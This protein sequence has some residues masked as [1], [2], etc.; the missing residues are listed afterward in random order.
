MEKATVYKAMHERSQELISPR[1]KRRFG[2]DILCLMGAL[3][4]LAS[5]LLYTR[6]HPGQDVVA[7]ALY[8]IGVII[9]GAP[10]LVTA[11]RG[12]IKQDAAAAMEI[13]VSI[14]IIVSAL[15]SQYILAI[16]I[17]VILTFVH[18]LEEKSILGGRDAIENLI[19]MQGTTALLIQDGKEI[20]VD[21][22]SLP[23]GAV[24]CIKPGAALPID[25]VVISGVSSIDQKSLTGEPLPQTVTE[26][27]RV[28]AGTTNIDGEIMIRVDRAFTDTSFQK[29]VRLLRE[30]ENISTPETRIVDRFM[31]Y[32]I[33]LAL[34]IATLVW[35][36]S[37]DITKAVAILVV[38]C[39]CGHM[40]ISS[41]PM[42]AALSAATKRGLLI[43]N[44]AFIEKLA[45]ADCIVFDKTGTLTKG[46]LE[47]SNYFLM[48]AS[49]FEE[50]VSSA[51]CVT[52]SSLH[53]VSKSITLLGEG[54]DYDRDYIVTEY[55]GKGM[56][57][58]KGSSD[59]TVG[60]RQWLLS[61]GYDIPQH[62]EGEGAA[63]WVIK[64]GAV[65]GCILFKDVPREGAAAMV[66][67]LKSLG[68]SKTILLTGD[69]ERAAE[70]IKNAV[71]I[72]AMYCRL[73]PEQKLEKVKALMEN[74]VVGVVG[75]GINDALALSRADIG[76]A[77]GAMG[78]DTAIQSADIALMNNELDN[79]TFAI[80]L[81]K[82]TKNAIFEN[83][84]IS[85]CS[86][87]IMIFLAA[88]GVVSPLMGA[89]LH[90]IGAFFVLFNSGRLLKKKNN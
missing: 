9:I 87:F 81:A 12:I 51:C 62:Y 90:N 66:N 32:Y 15:D 38:S 69:S 79:I 16:L 76:I 49:G 55:V 10:V 8:V 40:L 19:K 78:S 28:F 82:R 67:D 31:A 54:M 24:I 75:D 85:F 2:R 27:S 86:S 72:D 34:I 88:A 50:L 3:A 58:K 14:A 45:K 46:N 1:D 18:F 36:F 77:M 39:P 5:G 53:P 84:I 6:L 22:K 4:C 63:S 43:K 21:A 73:L 47:A 23:V 25:G 89:F 30:A 71:G 70:K 44:S 80:R 64:D 48:E 52:K 7:G 42:I 33:P 11:A 26:G 83:I 29:I 65:L 35:L 61:L 68:V 74:H 59:I 57:G 13:L 17:P 20:E 60:N 56:V 41:A 37:Q